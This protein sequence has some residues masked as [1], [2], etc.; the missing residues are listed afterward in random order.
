MDGYEKLI[1]YSNVRPLIFTDRY[2]R[3]YRIRKLI[4]KCVLL[5]NY[6]QKIVITFSFRESLLKRYQVNSLQI[7]ETAS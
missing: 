6:F 7:F 1:P 2:K 5:A 3:R 4:S